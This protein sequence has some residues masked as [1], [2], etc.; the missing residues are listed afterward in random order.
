M[1]QRQQNSTESTAVLAPEQA[2]V[3][4]ALAQGASVT[5]ATRQAGVDRTTFYFWVKS[6]ALFQAELNR[7]DKEQRDAMR[8]QVRGL[9]D[10]AVT[11][12]R[13]M[14]TGKDIPAGVRLKA[15]LAV[16][17]SAGTLEAEPIG[18]ID[19]EGIE[20]DRAFEQLGLR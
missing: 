19:P 5:D 1:R 12:L 2:Q 20:S 14:L 6:D 4:V 17:Q 18:R 13:E 3:I 15:A 7:A 11:T 16:L 10:T 9:A 8:S